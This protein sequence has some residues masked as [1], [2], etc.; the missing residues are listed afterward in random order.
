MFVPT[1]E[2]TSKVT[3]FVLKKFAQQLY[4]LEEQKRKEQ[5]MYAHNMS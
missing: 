2:E 4:V 1:G 3:A 5:G